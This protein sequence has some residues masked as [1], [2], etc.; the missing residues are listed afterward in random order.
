[1]TMTTTVRLPGAGVPAPA[2]AR[3]LLLASSLL[4][5][6][7]AAVALLL[8]PSTIFPTSS[9][10]SSSSSSRPARPSRLEPPPPLLGLGH[11][12]PPPLLLGGPPGRRRLL[13]WFEDWKRSGP[14]NPALEDRIKPIDAPPDPSSETGE[15]SLFFY[16][17][18]AHTQAPLSSG[19]MSKF[20]TI[21]ARAGP[22]ATRGRWRGGGVADCRVE[23]ETRTEGRGYRARSGATAS[24]R[25]CLY[26]RNMELSPGKIARKRQIDDAEELEKKPLVGRAAARD[27]IPTSCLRVGRGRR[28]PLGEACHGPIAVQS[29][30]RAHTRTYARA[31]ASIVGG[32]GG[33]RGEPFVPPTPSAERY[34]SWVWADRG[35]ERAVCGGHASWNLSANNARYLLETCSRVHTRM[36]GGHLL[37]GCRDARTFV[38]QNGPFQFDLGSK[39][40]VADYR[41][42]LNFCGTK[43]TTKWPFPGLVSKRKVVS[44]GTTLKSLYKCM[45]RTL[46]VRVGADPRWGHDRD[47]ELVVLSPGLTGANF[48][49]VDTLSRKGILRAARLGLVPSGVADL[50]VTSNLN[51]AVEHL[52]D[53]DH[54]GR[55][56]SLFRHPVDRLVSKFFYSQVATWERS[57]HPQWQDMNLLEWAENVNQEKDIAVRTLANLKEGAEV[58]EADLRMAVWTARQLLVIGLMDRMEESIRRFNVFMGIDGSDEIDRRCTDEYFGHGQRKDNSNAHPAV[59]PDDPAYQILA[60]DNAYDIQLHEILVDLFDR[61]GEVVEAHARSIGAKRFR[62][63]QRVGGD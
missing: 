53:S 37:R 17:I 38:T 25:L 26:G 10:S 44:G 27:R 61:Q 12:P 40:N 36:V 42:A 60:R 45:N 59:G 54:P 58:T 52:Y 50:V 6:A 28:K 31:P 3:A 46:A 41:N 8:A 63:K 7:S 16:F 22:T 47:P 19:R 1:M 21:L 23:R 2:P 43:W 48:V 34:I 56:F 20:S 32:G 35:R 5:V 57:Y 29:H 30:S 4:L 51:F 14:L 13:K 62:M 49:N 33:R 55:V 39:Q 9:S 18:L 24:L 15:L 11:E